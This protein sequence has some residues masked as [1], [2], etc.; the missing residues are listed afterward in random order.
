MSSWTKADSAAGAPLW[1]ATQF[2][3]A[4]SS[5][6]RTS[7]YNGSV[8][9]FITGVTLAMFNY[10]TTETQSGKIA[11]TG[12]VVSITGSGGRSSRTQYETLV[13]LTSN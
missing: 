9:N 4:P 11:H 12:W 5:A 13:C 3:Q 10:D 6:N 2:N 8:T 7:L 1:A